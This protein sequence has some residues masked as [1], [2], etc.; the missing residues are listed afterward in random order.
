MRRARLGARVLAL[1]IAATFVVFSA[2]TAA[3]YAEIVFAKHATDV[4]FDLF[5]ELDDPLPAPGIS[6]NASFIAHLSFTV[7]NPSDRRLS[8]HYVGYT[9][10]VHD[11]EAENGSAPER[12]SLDDFLFA[13][14]GSVMLFYRAITGFAIFPTYTE[15]IDARSEATFAYPFVLDRDPEVI[16]FDATRDIYEYAANVGIPETNVGWFHHVLVQLRILDVPTDYEETTPLFY[17]HTL[18]IIDREVGFELG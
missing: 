8:I 9:G 10:W 4:V 12:R 15:F 2:A 14:D 7:R 18:P 17:L 1:G 13:P 11:Y 3:N 6:D 5:V 16:R